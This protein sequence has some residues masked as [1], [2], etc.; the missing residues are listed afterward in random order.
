MS[1]GPEVSEGEIMDLPGNGIPKKT[2]GGKAETEEAKMDRWTK[3]EEKRGLMQLEI[4]SAFEGKLS[5]WT[6]ILIYHM[7]LLLRRKEVRFK[8]LGHGS[9]VSINI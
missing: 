8:R 5:A 3:M 4:E 1:F 6:G 7:I 9:I 2:D